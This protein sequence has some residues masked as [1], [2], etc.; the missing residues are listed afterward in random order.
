MQ[1]GLTPVLEQLS[2]AGALLPGSPSYFGTVSGEMKSFMERLFFLYHTNTIPPESL[3]GKKIP[4]AFIYTMNVS[5]HQ[6]KDFHLIVHTGLNEILLRRMFGH[7]ESLFS[8][9]TL[10][11]ADF[12]NVVFTYYDPEERKERRRTVFPKDCEKVFNL[13][14]RLGT[15]GFFEPFT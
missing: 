6:V 9:G 14:V 8:F 13:G 4:A 10:Q 12:S 1:D 7:A 2:E 11:F 5:E 3:F 15:V